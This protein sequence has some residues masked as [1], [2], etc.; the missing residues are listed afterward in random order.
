MITSTMQE[1]NNI[2]FNMSSVMASDEDY[3]SCL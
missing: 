2:K 1:I 3:L